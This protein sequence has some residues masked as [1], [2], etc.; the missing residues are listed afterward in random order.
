MLQWAYFEKEF[1]MV[2]RVASSFVR[3]LAAAAPALVVA[4]GLGGLVGCGGDGT[5]VDPQTACK[6]DADCGGT[7]ATPYCGADLTCVACKDNSQ[8]SGAKPVCEPTAHTC[9]ACTED[10][11]CGSGVCLD[12]LGTCA[13]PDQLL[14]VKEAGGTNN[15]TCD[16]QNPCDSIDNAKNK[17]TAQRNVI[18]VVGPLTKKGDL[19]VKATI[20][21]DG[22]TWT[23][24]NPLVDIIPVLSVATSASDVTVEGFSLVGATANPTVNCF[25]GGTLRLHEVSV[26][27]GKVSGITVAGKLTVTKSQILN[28]LNGGVACSGATSSLTIEDTEISGNTKTTIETLGCAV[29]LARNRISGNPGPMPMIALTDP[30]K[31]EVENNLVWDKEALTSSG[32]SVV[33]GPAAGAVRFNTFVRTTTGTHTGEGVTCTGASVVTSNVVAWQSGGAAV[34]TCTRRYNAFDANTNVGAGE[35]NA[36]AAFS[37]LFVNPATDFH[38]AAGSPAHALAEPGVSVPV[39]LEG[40]ARP[41]SGRLDAGAYETP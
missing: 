15:A 9:Q 36:S 32:L 30:S 11:Q 35:G 28:N 22:S 8:C 13:S 38:L 24:G 27:G 12:T 19:Q 14:Y 5:N 21:G 1:D 2:L 16:A 10:S 4:L 37:A 18:R 17:I 29:R 23:I 7:P 40:K 34:G 3:R 31:L 6:T 39:D 41:A 20:D 33:N 26:S 25:A